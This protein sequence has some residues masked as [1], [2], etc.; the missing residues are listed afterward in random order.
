MSEKNNHNKNAKII[1]K[2]K[3]NVF[4]IQITHELPPKINKNTFHKTLYTK[5]QTHFI[6]LKKKD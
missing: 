6:S 3:K 5:Q 4:P 2:F 1:K